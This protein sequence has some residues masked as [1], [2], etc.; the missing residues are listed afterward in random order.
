MSKFITNSK[1]FISQ[2]KTQRQTPFFY[3]KDQKK[4]WYSGILDNISN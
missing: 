1:Q 3:E 4:F 2:M